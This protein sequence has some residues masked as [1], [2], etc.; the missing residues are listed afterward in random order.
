MTVF[1]AA[2]IFLS[3]FIYNY[4]KQEFDATAKNQIKLISNVLGESNSAAIL[5]KDV[6]AAK[7]SLGIAHLIKELTQVEILDYDTQLIAKYQAE[8]AKEFINLHPYYRVKQDT[9]LGLQN[10][11]IDIHPIIFEGDTIGKVIVTHDKRF[12][13]DKFRKYVAYQFLIFF[14]I[15]LVAFFFVLLLQRFITR[16]I[17]SLIITMKSV[18]TDNDY[19]VRLHPKGKDEIGKMME[20]FDHMLAHI[21]TQSNELIKSKEQAINLAG[22]KDKFL[23]QMSHE[24]RTPLNAIFG[25]ITLFGKTELTPDQKIYLGYVKSSLENLGGII[26]DVLDFSKIE[27]GKLV[28]E[29]KEF[30]LSD[31]LNDLIHVFE[32]KAEEKNLQLKLS[33]AEEVPKVIVADKLRVNQVFVNL[34]GN[35]IKFTEK[36]NISVIAEAKKLTSKYF[37]ITFSVIDTGVGIPKD[38]ADKIFEEFQQ[39]SGD[40]TIKYGGT[41][42]GLSI[43]KKLIEMHNGKLAVKSEPGKGSSFY[44][45]LDLEGKETIAGNTKEDEVSLDDIKKEIADKKLKLLVAE[46]NKLNQILIKKILLSLNMLVSIAENGKE[47]IALLEEEDFDLILMDI[48]MPIMDGYQATE[49]IRSHF[50]NDPDKKNIPIIALSAAVTEAERKKAKHLG[51]NFFIPKPFKEEEI[52]ETVKNAVK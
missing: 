8:N 31:M 1:L 37:R 39:A 44:F 7:K 27:A 5:F 3:I 25:F 13:Q 40:V 46:D 26:N 15:F 14:I 35:A 29:K 36:G 33:I 34:I 45:A 43:S 11:F 52:I 50:D 51:M 17:K 6:D 30:D 19:S 24:I 28:I 10:F 16:P 22:A 12:F 42:L 48:Q 18:T 38:K 20:V 9:I 32:P 49:H 4:S 23:A 21:E 41:G 2:F 47:A